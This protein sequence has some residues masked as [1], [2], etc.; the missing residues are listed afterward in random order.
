MGVST[1]KRDGDRTQGAFRKR[2][3]S[4]QDRGGGGRVLVCRWLA[5]EV[6]GRARRRNGLE[7]VHSGL[8]QAM[9][10]CYLSHCSTMVRIA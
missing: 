2:E 10:H 8:S 1:K 3:E 5:S 9:Q 6:D 4:D 7:L